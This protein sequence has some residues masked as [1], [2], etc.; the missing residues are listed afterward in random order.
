MF[1]GMF[2]VLCFLVLIL[3]FIILLNELT[4]GK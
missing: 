2:A 3:Q 1:I 4:I